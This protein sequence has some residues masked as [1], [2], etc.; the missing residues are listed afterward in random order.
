V[1]GPPKTTKKGG[2]T[3]ISLKYA[4]I[5]IKFKV[6]SLLPQKNDQKCPKMGVRLKIV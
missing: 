5:P 2:K 6:I 1:G 4:E 3:E